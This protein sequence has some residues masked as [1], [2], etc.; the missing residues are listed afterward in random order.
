MLSR[1]KSFTQWLPV[2]AT[3]N[4]VP[5]GAP[6]N[7]LT[8]N[9]PGVTFDSLER[10]KQFANEVDAIRVTA[11]LGGR[12]WRDWTWETGVVYSESALEQKQSNLIFK[13]NLA[14]AIAGGYDANGNAMVGGGFSR[15]RGGFSPTG[16]LVLQPALDPFA[17]AAGVNPAA[18]TNL[19]GTEVI[20][21]RSTL[22][23]VD[24]KVVGA[25]FELPAGEV[26]LAFGV[27]V[28]R[29]VL[30]GH[31]DA[32]GRVTDPVTGK[33]PSID[34]AS[35]AQLWLGGTFADPFKK[36]RTIESIFA[37]TRIPITGP[38]WNLP[39]FNAFDL[40]LAERAERYSDAG[41]STVPK[42][43]FRWQPLDGQLTV[44]GNYSESYSAPTLFAEYGPVNQR[45]VGAGVIQGVFGPNY[46]AMPFNGEDGN[47][48][49]L[50]PATSISRSIGIVFKPGMLQGFSLS[51]DYSSITL[52]GFAG[53]IGFNNIL[54]SVNALGQASPYFGNLAVDGFPGDPRATQPFVNPGDLQAF[55]T[56]PVSGKGDPAQAARLYVVDQ[57][58][59][60]ATLIEHSYNL[61]VDYVL[62]TDRLG[63]FAFS[64]TGAIFTSFN[65]QDLPGH[66]YIQYAGHTNNA[67]GSG[68]FGGTLPKYRFFTTVDWR[69]RDLDISLANTY[70]A[71]TTDTGLNGT[72]LPEIPVDRYLAWDFRV[73]YD[74]HLAAGQD[75]KTVSFA[76]GA[77]NFT[78]EMPPLAPRAFLDNNAD[79]STFSP[80]GRLI[81]GTLSY[82]F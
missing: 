79:V 27:S 19:Y 71:S 76:L 44:R 24:A 48:P 10:P 80:I 43:G 9:F 55:L 54:P 16:D 11:G 49:D 2:A 20:N 36:G 33:T 46:T 35:N 38:G 61:S 7:P 8:T 64:T 1:S 56:S 82:S 45:Q 52:R 31:A 25:V 42:I 63:T 70:V 47:N 28:R 37:E 58:R 13:P 34:P 81:Y 53:G 4:S 57:F 14:P 78:D 74:W 6:Y 26:D 32:N 68:G 51:A 77:N 23:S 65:F 29:E 5:A 40:T 17:R 72:A 18:L 62:A 75:R 12:L 41:N 22:S 59:N 15:V 50:K 66:A 30:S 39:G 3:G 21:A 60:L 73:A 69:I 67:G